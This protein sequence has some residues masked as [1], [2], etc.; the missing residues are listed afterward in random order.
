II[1]TADELSFPWIHPEA[2]NIDEAAKKFNVT[3]FGTGSNPGFLTDVLP[4]LLTS[5]CQEVAEIKVKR[6]ADF[7][8]YGGGVLKQ[9]GIGL[10]REDWKEAC[11]KGNVMGHLASRGIVNYIADCMDLKLDE[12]RER[13]ESVIA[14]VPRVGL[15]CK[16]DK[17]NVAGTLNIAHGVKDGRE[18]IIFEMHGSIQPETEKLKVGTFWSI[19][20]KPSFE[21]SIKSKEI[22]AESVL[23]TSARVVN[24]IPIVTKSKP[25]LLT[26][27]DLPLGACIMR[28]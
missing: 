13:I 1:S 20:G 8:P 10:S 5:G 15:Y 14:K 4:A 16:V 24:S 6:V 27:K 26:Q 18:L 17:G 22:A 28:K 9:F 2:K 11:E 21:G 7:S 12:V 3:V 19:K 25:G 23:V